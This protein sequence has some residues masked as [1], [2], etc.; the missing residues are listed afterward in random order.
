MLAIVIKTYLVWPYTIYYVSKLLRLKLLSY[1]KSILKPLIITAV[2]VITFYYMKSELILLNV[3]YRILIEVIISVAIC[4]IMTFLL[5][6][7]ELRDTFQIIF[8]RKKQNV[9]WR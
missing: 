3:I 4:L 6:F 8:K 7:K 9:Q 5:S 2:M 1:I